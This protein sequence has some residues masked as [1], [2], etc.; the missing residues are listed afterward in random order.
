MVLHFRRLDSWHLHSLL[1]DLKESTTIPSFKTKAL[2]EMIQM[3]VWRQGLRNHP[4]Q[5][6][7]D[8][9]PRYLPVNSTYWVLVL[10]VSST[11]FKLHI[12]VLQREPSLTPLPREVYLSLQMNSCW[13]FPGVLDASAQEFKVY[14]LISQKRRRLTSPWLPWVFLWKHKNISELKSTPAQPWLT[15]E[16]ALNEDGFLS[17][18]LW[19]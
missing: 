7:A 1:K 4:F 18:N 8:H 9:F 5:E 15:L 6:H 2:R 14:A 19:T 13:E 17:S 11:T 3:P 10:C 16:G 12:L